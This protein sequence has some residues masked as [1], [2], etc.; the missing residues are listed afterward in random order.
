[1]ETIEAFKLFASFCLFALSCLLGGR[2]LLALLGARNTGLGLSG[3]AGAVGLSI[4]ALF[5]CMIFPNHLWIVNVTV[6]L[7]GIGGGLWEVVGRGLPNH[8]RRSFPYYALLAVCALPLLWGTWGVRLWGDELNFSAILVRGWM[9]GGALVPSRQPQILLPGYPRLWT[10]MIY[11]SLLLKGAMHEAA[12]RWV[13]VIIMWF[14]ACFIWRELVS[15]WRFSRQWSLAGAAGFMVLS[16]GTNF[17]YSLSW[18]FTT[19]IAV[20]LLTALYLLILRIDRHRRTPWQLPVA[21]LLLAG[22]TGIRPDGFLYLPLVVGFTLLVTGRSILVRIRDCLVLVAPSLAVYAAWH[23]YTKAHGVY[24]STIDPA[25]AGSFVANI[26]RQGPEIVWGMVDLFAQEWYQTGIFFLIWCLCVVWGVA[27]FGRFSSAERLLLLLLL[28]PVYK[29]I[30]L[31]A[32]NC[33]FVTSNAIKPR[34]GRHLM[35]TAPLVYFLLTFLLLKFTRTDA[36]Q[37]HEGGKLRHR[38]WLPYGLF[39]SLLAAMV[40]LGMLFASLPNQINDYVE[41]LAATARQKMPDARRVMFI[42]QGIFANKGNA[43][44]LWRYYSSAAPSLYAPGY[45]ELPP[46]DLEEKG[47]SFHG[48]LLGKGVD[49]VLVYKADP[50]LSVATELD[51]RD[52]TVYLL[53]VKPK[54][55]VKVWSQPMPLKNPWGKHWRKEALR[56][57]ISGSGG[58]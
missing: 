54:G 10:L 32:E 57:L 31:I 12:G 19:V 47:W 46:A 40:F 52:D 33:L 15:T 1:M 41:S 49:G 5:L 34:L 21:A 9:E 23:W 11:Q 45:E 53:A 44:C 28:A 7:A 27:R 51:L 56:R 48:S 20:L 3:L 18:Y 39:C 55:F 8:W 50:V 43:H 37:G 4:A 42:G 13:C 17:A 2:S 16:V 25:V 14:G 30:V 22:L 38:A 6:L 26:W 24:D 29:F 58:V 36:V 35:Q